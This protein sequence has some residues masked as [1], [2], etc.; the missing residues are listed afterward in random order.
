MDAM[1][2][3]VFKQHL[4]ACKTL[5]EKTTCLEIFNYSESLYNVNDERPLPE[6]VID[7]FLHKT[8]EFA[9]PDNMPTD[10]KLLSGKDALHADTF[11]DRTLSLNKNVY[12]SM[13]RTMQLP[14]KHIES[15]AVVGPF[16]WHH[17]SRQG[18]DPCLQIVYRKSDVRKH[19]KT[20]GFEMVLSHSFRT[21]LT[22]GFIK[23]TPTSDLV[24]VLQQMRAC[25][26]EAGHPLVLP[27]TF[28]T[29]DLSERNDMRQRDARTWLRRIENFT[30]MREGSEQDVM[31]ALDGIARDLTECYAHVLW[32]PPMLYSS[33]VDQMRKAMSLFANLAS[34]VQEEDLYFAS[35]DTI[36]DF[37]KGDLQHRHDNLL[38]RL[39]FT[40]AK[41]IGLEHY[42]ETT[43]ERLKLQRESVTRSHKLTGRPVSSNVWIYFVIMVPITAALVASWI[44][45]E[46]HRQ[47]Q[48]A[49]DDADFD[50]NIIKMESSIVKVIQRKTA[51]RSVWSYA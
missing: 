28:L 11:M 36:A 23:G 43:L 4:D 9:P 47:S 15:T 17:Y 46:R 24:E 45:F 32:R 1:D 12:E 33:L 18:D 25:P 19:D 44:W 41:L 35:T 6:E 20:R 10:L 3:Y 48:Y 39:D 37:G 34:L 5:L 51:V 21:N 29:R 22:S 14:T 49:K 7:D 26:A 38:S 30:T 2:D 8:G 13:V 27:V 40:Q 16:F 50:S 42:R 31:L